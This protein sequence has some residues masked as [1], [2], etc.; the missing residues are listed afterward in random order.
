MQ[1][2]VSMYNCIV[3]SH[4]DSFPLS[5]IITNQSSFYSNYGQLYTLNDVL[6]YQHNKNQ[7]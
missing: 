2:C 7:L 5:P 6:Y 4:L 1:Y 3:S